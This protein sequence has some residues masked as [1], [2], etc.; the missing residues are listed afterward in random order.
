MIVSYSSASK[1]DFLAMRSL[2]KDEIIDSQQSAIHQPVMLAEVLQF[3]GP[4]SGGFYLDATIG[5]GGHAEAILKASRPDG[6]LLGI[7]QDM[8]TLSLVGPR[9]APFQGRFHLAHANFSQLGEILLQRQWEGCDGIVFDLG[10]SS[11]QLESSERGFSFQKDGPLDMRMDRDQSITAGEIVNYYP[12]KDL[13]NILY[14]YGEEPFFRRIAR[15][16]V[17]ARPLRGT[18]QLA[19]IVAKAVPFKGARRIHP[20]TRTFQALRIFVNDELGRLAQ[21]LRGAADLLNPAG[22]MVVISF[23]SLEDRI[24]KE[25]FRQLSRECI[26]PAGT[27]A[28]TCG[29]RKTLGLLSKKPIQPDSAEMTLNPRS[30]SAKLRA[31]EKLK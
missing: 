18:L 23:H 25:T 24:V 29:N 6:Q 4:R 14:Q 31:A 27:T 17:R 7:D 22:R 12:E 11:F 26:C 10:I 28:C 13:A 16:I 20:A 9:L 1:L 21:A 15:S 2:R 8:D 30:R 3:L 19:E 5:L